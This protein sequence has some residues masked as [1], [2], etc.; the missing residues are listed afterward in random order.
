MVSIVSLVVA[1][2]RNDKNN[3]EKCISCDR[4][5]FQKCREAGETVIYKCHMGLTESATP[6]I[7]NDVIVGYILFGQLLCE[8]SRETLYNISKRIYGMGISEYIR[9]IQIK[10]LSI[11]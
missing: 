10:R 1:V 4:M 7:D 5:V 6:I 9:K 3:Y 8:N 11:L 2:V